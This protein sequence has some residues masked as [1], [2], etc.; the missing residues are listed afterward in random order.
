MGVSVMLETIAWAVLLM[1]LGG[2]VVV[3]VA[4]SIFMLGSVDDEK[5]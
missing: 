2:V 4:V 1:C 3:V 5:R